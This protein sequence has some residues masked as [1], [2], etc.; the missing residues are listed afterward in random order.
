MPNVT[1]RAGA[2]GLPSL[3]RRA[4]LGGA[5]AALALLQGPTDIPMGA[6]FVGPAETDLAELQP[7]KHPWD[8]ARRLSDDLAQV[9]SE[10]E[11]GRWRA[12][13]WP[14]SLGEYPVAFFAIDGPSP[15]AELIADYRW[16]KAEAE[17]LFATYVNLED[18]TSLP[19][20]E[21]FFGR[22][23]I[24]SEKVGEVSWGQ[25]RAT[26]PEEVR[27]H[28]LRN[29]MYFSSKRTEI[30]RECEDA[31]SRLQQAQQ[32]YDQAWK[33]SGLAAAEVAS[34]AAHD[35]KRQATRAIFAYHPATMAE[36]ELKNSFLEE[37]LDE[38]YKFC[39]GDLTQIFGGRCS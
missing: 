10:V 31:L 12:E 2:E 4:L 18:R 6:A 1:A 38:G 36:V 34:D 15:L 24:V 25:W 5:G 39:S 37:Q 3:N 30:E 9:M 32:A 23:Q 16:K 8:R 17:R 21:V 26:T 33:E 35:A 11:N 22:V 20:V 7:V 29:I 13:I 28:Y 19:T 27:R 14:A